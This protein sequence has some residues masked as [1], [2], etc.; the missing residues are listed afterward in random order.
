MGIMGH[1]RG[2][3]F[4]NNMKYNQAMRSIKKYIIIESKRLI[5]KTSVGSCLL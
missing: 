1:V 5:N 3:E 2:Q 4:Q